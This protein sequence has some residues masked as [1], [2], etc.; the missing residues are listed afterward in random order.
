[1][2]T[3]NTSSK[4][5]LWYVLLTIGIACWG[6]SAA[7]LV[8]K[9][10]GQ[11][12]GVTRGIPMGL[13]IS[14]YEFFVA[15][16]A[17]LAQLAALG[18]GF[19][20]GFR[21]SSMKPFAS[22]ALALSVIATVS[23]MLVLSLELSHPIR[24]LW[25]SAV[26]PNPAS[27]LW[28]MG[29][30]YALYFAAV[31]GLAWMLWTG[32]EKGARLFA[33]LTFGASAFSLSNM[34]A[35]LGVLDARALW[36]GSILP[37]YFLASGIASAASALVLAIRF[38]WV[39]PEQRDEMLGLLRKLLIGCVTTMIY[40]EYVKMSPGAYGE[41]LEKHEATMVLLTGP[42]AV[43]FW[44]FEILIGLVLPLAALLFTRS[45]K[46]VVF[47]AFANLVGVFAMRY[48]LVIA[49]QMIPVREGTGDPVTGL[50]YYSATWVE[51]A[52]VIGALSAGL[53]VY[54]LF[55]KYILKIDKKLKLA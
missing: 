28:L 41:L 34:G 5:T 30:C 25:Y 45:T 43:N 54:S 36:H 33:L 27:P 7:V 23:G 14:S 3:E 35:V 31:I 9:G 44:V 24:L 20:P 10:H 32:N 51:W 40:V 42:L 4:T 47:A 50:L 19:G 1:M 52:I 8:T 39:K 46:A 55:R 16:G 18:V 37:I 21:F 53:L 11:S 26:S 2:T 38:G 48:D 49:G 22:R 12:F 13:L 29:M 15:M 17:G 6:L